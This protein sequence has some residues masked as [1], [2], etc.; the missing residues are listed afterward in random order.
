M[1]TLL[2]TVR[3]LTPAP[4]VPAPLRLAFLVTL[5][6]ASLGLL[7]SLA[8]SSA[9]AATPHRQLV[10]L[11]DSHLVIHDDESWP[12]SDEEHTFNLNNRRFAIVSPSFPTD[13]RFFSACVGDEVRAE[14]DVVAER[15][16]SGRV[17][18]KVILRLYEG[19]NCAEPYMDN[20]N[21]RSFNIVPGGSELVS[22]STSDGA[23][24]WASLR[25]VLKN[26]DY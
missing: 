26:T 10:S 13:I 17:K 15:E 20:W 11:P 21:S 5:V 23:H 12:F 14:Y 9:S 8:A 19:T 3:Q 1:S 24:S 16:P 22:M 6:V 25:L 18:G 7:G 4:K 2:P